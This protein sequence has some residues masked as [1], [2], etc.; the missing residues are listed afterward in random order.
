LASVSVSCS[1]RVSLGV[2]GF[3]VMIAT[4]VMC[5]ERKKVQPCLR[6]VQKRYDLKSSAL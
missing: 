6:L 1:A 5:G 2:E 4:E 3:G